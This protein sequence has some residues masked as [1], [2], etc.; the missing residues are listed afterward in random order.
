MRRRSW[1]ALLTRWMGWERPRRPT[2]FR[3]DGSFCRRP[4]FPDGVGCDHPTPPQ[5]SGIGV[6]TRCRKEFF[7][8]TPR[9]GCE[10]IVRTLYSNTWLY[11]CPDCQTVVYIEWRT[12]LNRDTPDSGIRIAGSE[13]GVS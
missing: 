8:I 13:D 2:C 1:W 6:C 12:T 7:S 5:V 4:C 3:A 9:P 11:C 10:K